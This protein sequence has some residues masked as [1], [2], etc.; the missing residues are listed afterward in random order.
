[1][2]A[3]FIAFP[4]DP[5]M[6]GDSRICFG[7]SVQS[8]ASSGTW[9]SNNDCIALEKTEA[10]LFMNFSDKTGQ[11]VVLGRVGGGNAFGD[12]YSTQQVRLYQTPNLA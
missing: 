7:D 6:I 8:T 5:D 3:A 12:Y 9:T 2:V 4:S 1:M 10:S 11:Y